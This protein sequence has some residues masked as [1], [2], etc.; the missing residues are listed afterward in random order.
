MNF[1]D[2][3]AKGASRLARLGFRQVQRPGDYLS[4]TNAETGEVCSWPGE[5][6]GKLGWP[7]MSAWM[8]ALAGWLSY[9]KHMSSIA[10]YVKVMATA[11]AAKRQAFVYATS[12]A[13]KVTD[14]LE[15]VKSDPAVVQCVAVVT[16]ATALIK[17]IAGHVE[18][19]EAK[20]QAVSRELS[21]RKIEHS[22]SGPT[23]NRR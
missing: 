17:L 14:K 21:L 4:I 10:D 16:E 1:D 3:A 11:E 8:G 13:T 22:E 12:T 18:G 2:Y 20:A 23:G 6:L 9:A 7:A 19:F 15:D 5:E